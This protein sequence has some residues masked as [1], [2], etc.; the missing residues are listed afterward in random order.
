[1]NYK[2]SY[3][4]PAYGT[5]Y[6]WKD[7]SDKKYS[8]QFYDSRTKETK[9][10]TANNYKSLKRWGVRIS[11][12]TGVA[13]GIGVIGGI[14]FCVYFCVEKKNREIQ[15]AELYGPTPNEQV[16]DVNFSKKATA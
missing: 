2:N 5:N 12:I 14:C 13:V 7:Y 10:Y 6:F 16:S 3:Y 11:V 4:D 9:Y 8:E 15:E 1:M